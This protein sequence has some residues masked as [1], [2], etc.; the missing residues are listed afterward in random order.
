MRLFEKV[1]LEI[2]SQDSSGET[3]LPGPTKDVL[4]RNQNEDD[5]LENSRV[6]PHKMSCLELL[7]MG[8]MMV[9]RWCDH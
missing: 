8:R 5:D 4:L 7:R 6:D 9:G 1:F 3:N 2:L